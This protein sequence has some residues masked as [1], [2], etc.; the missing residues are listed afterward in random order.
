MRIVQLVTPLCTA[1]LGLL[2]GCGFVGHVADRKHCY[3]RTG[4]FYNLAPSARTL[5]AAKYEVKTQYDLL[6]CGYL[7]RHPPSFDLVQ[8]LAQRGRDVIP[9]LQSKLQ[10]EREPMAI[11]AILTVLRAMEQSSSY[12]VSADIKLIAAAKRAVGRI[13]DPFWQCE[14]QELIQAFE[15]HPIG[16][17]P[18]GRAP[19]D[20]CAARFP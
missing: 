18:A 7:Y 14:G 13:E 5:Y 9:L 17:P 6:R 11:V 20:N 1:V 12:H 10:E 16:Q 8:P 4:G 19:T 2:V 3:D 15:L